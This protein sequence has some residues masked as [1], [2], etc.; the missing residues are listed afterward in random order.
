MGRNSMRQAMSSL[1]FCL[2]L[3]ESYLRQICGCDPSN[4]CAHSCKVQYNHNNECFNFGQYVQKTLLSE[5][6]RLSDTQLM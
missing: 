6:Y 5:L 2:C 1:N 4:V 3:C